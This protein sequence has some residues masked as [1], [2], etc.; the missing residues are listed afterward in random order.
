M[1]VLLVDDHTV[2]RQALRLLL[3]AEPDITIVGEASNGREAVELT[4]DLQPEVVLMDVR[5][6]EMD[7]IEATRII[8]ADAPT[9]CVIGLSMFDHDQ[10]GEALRDAG[11][12]DYVTKNAPAAAVLTVMRGCY[13][14]LRVE[15]P[16]QAAA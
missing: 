11:A 13:A 14:R 12:M 3:E 1:R 8:H 2:V 5:M 16:P 7:G 6:P 9:I 10:Q 4:R 15:L